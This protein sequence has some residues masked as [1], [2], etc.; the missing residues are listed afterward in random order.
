MYGTY[1]MEYG[2]LNKITFA[3]RMCD[4]SQQQKTSSMFGSKTRYCGQ[5]KLEQ[6]I[7]LE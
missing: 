1:G 2:T 7:S 3:T 4:C 5:L 6:Q